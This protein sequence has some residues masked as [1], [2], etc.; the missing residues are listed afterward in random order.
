MF[1]AKEQH[2]T[3]SADVAIVGGSLAG[4]TAARL[5]ARE[6]LRVA[7][8]EKHSDP[9][10]YKRL[11]G[12][13]I[14]ASATPVL[15]RL[16]LAEQIEAAGGVRNGAD[17]WTRW[18]WIEPRPEAGAGRE[19]GFSIRRSKLDPMIRRLALETD[20]VTY[21][22]G[23]RAHELL[24]DGDRITGV[25][26]RDRRGR[27]VHVGA[28]LVVGA[29]GRNSSVA[30]LAKAPERTRP[31]NRFCYMAYYTGIDQRRDG[32]ARFWMLDPDV[33]IAAPN[34]DGVTLVALFAHKRHL[35]RF[36]GDREAAFEE[37]VWAAPGAPVPGQV[38]RISKFVGYTDYTIVSRPPVPRAGL[39]LA[40][41]AALTMDP[42]FAIGCGWALQSASWLVDAAAPALRGDEPL[43]RGLRRYRKEHRR[44]LAGHARV[45][46]DGARGKRPPLPVRTIL[47]AATRDPASA[48]LFERF[49]TRSIPVRRFLAPSAMARAARV[50]TRHRLT[51]RRNASSGSVPA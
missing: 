49:A 10:A 34:D 27:E 13:F 8:I 42:L 19:F 30:K 35:S 41:D 17:A 22:G 39:A 23:V 51:T 37:L 33:V 16:G 50:N 15:E 3:L 14:Q 47:A 38:E 40:G 48:R 36:K 25:V 44:R 7:L 28:S 1:E 18:G 20:G 43:E 2:S 12:H 45:L 4:C 46:T 6:G 26:G 24:D 11:C 29:D 9:T 5:F 32:Q 21:L 31:N